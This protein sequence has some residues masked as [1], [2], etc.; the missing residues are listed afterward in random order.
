MDAAIA[1]LLM[2]FLSDGYSDLPIAWPNVD[3]TPPQESYVRVS[4]FKAPSRAA[5][6]TSH[7][8]LQGIL[9][10][11]VVLTEGAGLIG[12]MA[13]ADKITALFKRGQKLNGTG[14]IIHIIE[15]PTAGSP[16]EDMDRMHIPVSVRWECWAETPQ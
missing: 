10:A 14:F 2:G 3:F 11:T 1:N 7:D 8:R 9:Q 4:Y 16:F 13:E 5:T 12:G 6:I 15:P